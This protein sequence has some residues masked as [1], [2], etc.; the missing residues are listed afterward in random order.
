MQFVSFHILRPFRDG[1]L[2]IVRKEHIRAF[3]EP[4]DSI[5]PSSAQRLLEL[6]SLATVWDDETIA[7][8]CMCVCSV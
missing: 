4:E 7:G 6:V 3:A 8:V 2:C 1:Q 5:P